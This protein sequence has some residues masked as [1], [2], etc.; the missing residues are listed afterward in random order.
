MV[1]MARDGRCRGRE[2][3]GASRL[4]CLSLML[5]LAVVGVLRKVVPA[6]YCQ[7][8]YDEAKSPHLP[9]GLE[10]LGAQSRR[11]KRLLVRGAPGLSRMGPPNPSGVA[12]KCPAATLGA[13]EWQ[14]G[15]HSNTTT[16]S[17]KV[18]ADGAV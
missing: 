13:Q 17:G 12:T 9:G 3:T 14:A 2:R 5:A 10:E 11:S 18:R 6:E 15:S 7:N 1:T 4:G 8:G 16:P